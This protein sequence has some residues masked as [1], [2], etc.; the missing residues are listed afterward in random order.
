MPYIPK[1]LT[2]KEKVAIL[3]DEVLRYSRMGLQP[4]HIAAKLDIPTYSVY[5]YKMLL[6]KEGV[7]I[8]VKDKSEMTRGDRIVKAKV[9]KYYNS[10]QTQEESTDQ[11]NIPLEET[12]N[13]VFIPLEAKERENVMISFEEDGIKIFW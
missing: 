3:K 13:S 6:Q 4:R 8:S 2:H 12:N 10:L 9:I 1:T 7:D 5:N 11:E